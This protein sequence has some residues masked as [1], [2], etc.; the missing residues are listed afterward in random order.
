MG[1]CFLDFWAFARAEAVEVLLDTQ[2]SVA[3]L[4]ERLSMQVA[5]VM[6]HCLLDFWAFVRGEAAD[7]R[8]LLLLHA[9]M[10][11]F[12]PRTGAPRHPRTKE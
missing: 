3:I 7:V 10:K 9:V 12:L 5:Q 11:I 6:G 2:K 8:G 4:Q 1:H